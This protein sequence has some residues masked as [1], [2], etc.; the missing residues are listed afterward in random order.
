MGVGDGLRYARLRWLAVVDQ[1]TANNGQP[2]QTIAK[3]IYA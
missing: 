3:F 1:T 2:L